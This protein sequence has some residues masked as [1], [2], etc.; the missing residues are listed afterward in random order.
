MKMTKMNDEL[1]RTLDGEPPEV[2]HVPGHRSPRIAIMPTSSRPS[3][4]RLASGRLEDQPESPLV[5]E[6]LTESMHQS[7][8]SPF[9]RF[10][11]FKLKVEA[12]QESPG[13]LTEAAGETVYKSGFESEAGE[14]WL[15]IRFED[16]AEAAHEKENATINR[17]YPG[18]QK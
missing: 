12:P 3:P 1:Q 11:Q 5:S 2:P 18:L 14:D 9:P 7:L 17:L 10:A 13:A 16:E 8:R 15:P 4:R 6:K